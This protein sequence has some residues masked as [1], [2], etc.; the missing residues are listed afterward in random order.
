MVNGWL[1]IV[2]RE[3]SRRRPAGSGTR[4]LSATSLNALYEHPLRRGK[5][6]DVKH[7]FYCGQDRQSSIPSV[8]NFAVVTARDFHY[9]AMGQICWRRGVLILRDGQLR[10]RRYVVTQEAM[11]APSE[12]GRV[13]PC[14]EH[15]DRA[16]AGGP[17]PTHSPAPQRCR[18][19]RCGPPWRAKHQP[20]QRCAAGGRLNSTSLGLSLQFNTDH[21]IPF[22]LAADRKCL[23]CF[24]KQHRKFARY[25]QRPVRSEGMEGEGGRS[26]D[27]G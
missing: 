25:K 20:M 5:E 9:A 22:A 11:N 18:C 3:A 21:N 27:Q 23:A 26:S 12:I 8:S 19:R 24:H 15:P 2:C 6:F 17:R 7:A 1:T 13:K 14:Q 10:R 16:T 4:S